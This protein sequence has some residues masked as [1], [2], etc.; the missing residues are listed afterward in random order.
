MEVHTF[1]SEY[2]NATSKLIEVV[3]QLKTS[4][5]SLEHFEH[6]SYTWKEECRTLFSWQGKGVQV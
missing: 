2:P 4:I 1:R 5:P 6:Q 3:E